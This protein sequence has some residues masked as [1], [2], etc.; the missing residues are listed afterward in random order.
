[1]VD[2]KFDTVQESH[3]RKP[4]EVGL[5]ETFSGSLY[6]WVELCLPSL[7]HSLIFLPLGFEIIRLNLLK[8]IRTMSECGKV[9]NN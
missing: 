8:D 1:M 5:V 3:H 4:S 7:P 6:W 2:F 9:A